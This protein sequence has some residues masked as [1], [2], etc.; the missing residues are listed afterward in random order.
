MISGL[1]HGKGAARLLRNLGL[2]IMTAERFLR[3][4]DW[5]H[6]WWPE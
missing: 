4:N 2:R 1:Y 6:G 3:R 5:I